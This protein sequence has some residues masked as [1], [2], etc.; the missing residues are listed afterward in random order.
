MIIKRDTVKHAQNGHSQKDGMLLNYN[1]TSFVIKILVLS[2]FDM[3]YC[4]T[5]LR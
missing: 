1:K 5:W 3:F 2:I 4:T